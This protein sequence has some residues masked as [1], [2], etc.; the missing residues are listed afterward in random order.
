[1][2]GV[3]LV[4]LAL[5]GDN[6]LIIGATAAGLPARQRWQAIMLGGAGAILFRVMFTIAAALLLTL[7]LV[8]AIGVVVLLY[9]ALCGATDVRAL[10]I[11]LVLVADIALRA[12]SGQLAKIM[13][14]V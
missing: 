7:P 3:I 6:A 14:N 12:R 1:M 13:R 9:I 8:Q 4:D 2:G 5:S 11:G 10:G